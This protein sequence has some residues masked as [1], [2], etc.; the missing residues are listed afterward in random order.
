[1]DYNVET[2][3]E[4][5]CLENKVIWTDPREHDSIQSVNLL[6]LALNEIQKFLERKEKN[7]YYILYVTDPLN[8]EAK[9]GFRITYQGGEVAG[10]DTSPATQ[11]NLKQDILMLLLDK[12]PDSK[13][14]AIELMV[15]ALKKGKKFYAI[16]DDK[17]RE[18][19]IYHEG[20]YIPQGQSYIYEFIRNLLES[21]YSTFLANQVID[22]IQA[23]SFIEKEEFFE[24]KYPDE[25]V[26]EN[27]I[28]NVYTKELQPLSPDKIHFQKLDFPYDQGAECPLIEKY[29]DDTLEDQ[30][31]LISE[32][33]G[34]CLQKSY[35]YKKIIVQEGDKNT[36]KS[37]TQNLLLR[38][39]GVKSVSNLPLNRLISDNF[40]LGGLHNKILNTSGE[41][42]TD[43]VGN[44]SLLKLLS[45]E[46]AIDVKRKFLTDLKF[47]NYAKLIFACN[48]L[49]II[50]ADNA[51]WNRLIIFRYLKEF[52]EKEEYD[53]LSKSEQV[54]KGIKDNDILNK[55]CIK[56]EFSGLLNK[57]LDGLNQIKTKGYS[58]NTT[59]EE[60][61]IYWIRKSDSFR[62]F[63][64]DCV[65][66]DLDGNIIK[67]VLDRL[68]GK[69]CADNKI[70]RL[71]PKHIRF[72]L[73]SEYYVIDKQE[74]S[75]DR[76]WQGIKLKN[77]KNNIGL[78]PIVEKILFPN[79]PENSV[80]SVIPDNKEES[81][82]IL[83]KNIELDVSL[84]T[85]EKEETQ[86]SYPVPQWVQGSQYPVPILAHPFDNNVKRVGE[87]A[88]TFP[89]FYEVLKDTTEFINIDGT[90]EP[91]HK[92][93]ETIQLDKQ[94]ADILI[95]DKLIKEIK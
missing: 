48:K 50:E 68:Y 60:N 5:V 66:E 73:E 91:E 75:G 85:P 89:P 33:G 82:D 46:D 12:S 19:W 80:I 92:A 61:K 16:R 6:S 17:Q 76:V 79:R 26:V 31:Q 51:M 78:I 86:L 69:Y 74:S 25:I 90:T 47:F 41:I 43:F 4:K 3:M 29:F 59:A 81:Q 53:K 10:S 9:Y 58:T 88:V 36:A 8:K 65:E 27:G 13:G 57:F 70:K 72:V 87:S 63:C 2:E 71:T 94:I 93:G 37:T 40:S 84:M 64:L 21:A 55:I 30:K 1:M 77:N 45:G 52:I 67:G 62:A 14:E 49:P 22:R 34:D 15:N 39:F 42:T 83:N 56:Q 18:L 44:I 23:D 20:I 38:F 7:G 54:G 28:L 24:N 32:F 95:S 35:K 11:D